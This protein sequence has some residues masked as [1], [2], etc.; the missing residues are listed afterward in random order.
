MEITSGVAQLSTRNAH[1]WPLETAS[2]EPKIQVSANR[3]LTRTSDTVQVLLSLY[4]A[5]AR[6]KIVSVERSLSTLSS[7]FRFLH[8]VKPVRDNPAA[9][10]TE[11]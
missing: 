8:H 4:Q 2:S 1:A 7:A 11:K 5:E 3:Y 6:G 10:S 9:R